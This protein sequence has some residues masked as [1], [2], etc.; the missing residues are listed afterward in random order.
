MSVTGFSLTKD[1]LM[2]CA[3]LEKPPLVHQ[4]MLDNRTQRKGGEERQ[5]AQ[6]HD[7][8]YQQSDEQSAM[9]RQSSAGRRNT[10]L[11]GQVSGDGQH[12]VEEEEPAHE[13]RDSPRD[14]VP[15]RVVIG[16]RVS[17]SSVGGAA[18]EQ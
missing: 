3:M 7:R 1:S 17:A 16:D 11:R 14:V 12:R 5:R 10:L 15:W 8:P 13:H 4:E 18:G 6:D 9:R 2:I